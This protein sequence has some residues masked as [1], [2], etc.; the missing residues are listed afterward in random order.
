VSLDASLFCGR[1]RVVRRL[2]SGGAATV[3]LAE[4]ER[5]DRKVAVKRL[6]GAEVTEETAQRLRR[7]AR[8]MAS[9]HHPN[10]VS[11][12]D[13]LTEDDDLFLVMEYIEGETLS[14]VLRAGPLAPERVLELL[15]PVAE[16]LDEAHRHGVVHRDVKPSNILVGSAGMVKL[17]DLGLATAAE[18]TRIT[19][20]GSIL[21]TPAYMAPEQARPV[22][23]TPAVDVYSLATIVFEA[24]S[25]TL[26]RD[27]KTALAVLRQASTE[28]VPD[29][30]ER[31]PEL[32]GAVAAALQRAMALEPGARHRSASALLRDVADGLEPEPAAARQRRAAAVHA[33]P[34]P[35]AARPRRAGAGA[36]HTPDRAAPPRRSN[37]GAR[38]L[39]LLALAA[40]AAVVVAIVLAGAPDDEPGSR[41]AQTPEPT[42]TA[43]AEEPAP[44]P[45][46]RALSATATVR[47]F[48]RRAAAGDFAGAW[49]LAGPGMRAVFGDSREEL[50]RQLSSL[51]RIEFERLAVVDRADG[52][53]TVEVRSVA[54]HTD[55]VD[56]CSGTLRTVRSGGRWLVEPA[57]LQCTSS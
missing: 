13:M 20:P 26:P 30:R 28:P 35:P 53:A 19:P 56:R 40:A 44:E 47:A 42:A 52:S 33:A 2:G 51:Q 54:T 8:I 37:R 43:T 22:P 3:F 9:L 34:E 10:L 27:G 39:A 21:G 48:Y 49:R 23:C 1:Y 55:R 11:V 32:P 14:Q 4:D 16:A 31:R 45:T 6:H 12:Y 18:I 41:S 46:P 25:G 57:G 38:A 36:V 29:V 15:W 50:E 17:A 5:L 24:L 7:E